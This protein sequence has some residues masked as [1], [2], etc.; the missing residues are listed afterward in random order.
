ME[1]LTYEKRTIFLAVCSLLASCSS[2]QRTFQAF[3]EIQA[4]VVEEICVSF[5]ERKGHQLEEGD[6]VE[7]KHDLG[8]YD[9]VYV[10]IIRYEPKGTNAKLQ[11]TVAVLNDKVIC[12]LPDWSYYLNVYS[13]Q[14][15]YSIEDAY[16]KGIVDDVICAPNSRHLLH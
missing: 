2:T 8:V 12:V 1:G 15:S 4:D 11:E 9:D 13:G 14:V 5:C 7:I 16:E 6:E 3:G 10:D